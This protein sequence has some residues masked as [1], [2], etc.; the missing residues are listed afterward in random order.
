MKKVNGL[1]PLWLAHASNE[2]IFRGAFFLFGAGF[3]V[4]Y[5]RQVFWHVGLAA[6]LLK[7]RNRRVGVVPGSRYAPDLS[8][9]CYLF[10]E[11]DLLSI[12]YGFSVGNKVL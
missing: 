12:L 7:V 1:S 8:A 10:L 4:R 5:R 2:R 6:L 11:P 9:Y 3:T